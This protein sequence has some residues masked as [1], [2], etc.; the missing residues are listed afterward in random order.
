MLNQTARKPPDLLLRNCSL[1]A[2]S[3]GRIKEEI[4]AEGSLDV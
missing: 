1:L 3:T 4:G 2:I